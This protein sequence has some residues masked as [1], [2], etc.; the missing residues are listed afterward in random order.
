[1][2]ILNDRQIRQKINRLAIQ[3]LEQH[4]EEPILVLAGLNKNGFGFARKLQE[5]LLQRK[6]EDMQIWMTK[7]RLN[8]AN[9]LA[10]LPEMELKP[11]ELHQKPIILVDDVAN[12][13]R[14]IFYAF[15]PLLQILPKKVEV[16]VLVDRKHKSF[17]INADYV[18]LTLA[19]TL[20]NNIVVKLPENEGAMSVD[21]E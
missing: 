15:Q 18:G 4:Y 20:L 16:A 7:V 13:G 2:Q 9:P 5:A 6:P 10:Y 8:P 12:T 3:I 17:P 19:T 14:T 11:E 1:M 21:L